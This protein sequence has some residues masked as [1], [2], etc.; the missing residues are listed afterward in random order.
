MKGV[1]QT[2]RV[3]ALFVGADADIIISRK[4]I[5]AM[6]P[7]VEDLEIRMIAECGHWTQQEKPDELNRIVLDWLTRRYPV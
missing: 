5:E 2:I 4:Q 3:P 1:D 6:K 7:Y